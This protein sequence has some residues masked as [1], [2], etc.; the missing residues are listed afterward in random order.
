MMT[1]SAIT[2]LAL[3]YQFSFSGCEAIHMYFVARHGSRYNKVSQQIEL[4]A[5]LTQ[6]RDTVLKSPSELWNDSRIDTQKI[7][8]NHSLSK[9]ILIRQSLKQTSRIRQLKTRALILYRQVVSG[10]HWRAHQLEYIVWTD[11]RSHTHPQR[12]GRISK[13]WQVF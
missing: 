1:M 11:W 8:F 5:K 12:M 10:R 4:K 2:M 9:C 13:Y 6:L 7:C 3:E